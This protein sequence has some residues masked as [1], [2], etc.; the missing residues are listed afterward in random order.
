VGAA[1]EIGERLLVG[2]DVADAGAPSMDMLQTVMRSS[3]ENASKTSP[4][5]S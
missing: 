1:L 2:V 4:P 3:I 5:Y